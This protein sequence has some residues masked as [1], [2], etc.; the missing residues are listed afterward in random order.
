VIN[1][2]GLGDTKENFSN[3]GLHLVADTGNFIVVT[4]QALS[5]PNYNL[6]AWNSGA[7]YMGIV[8]NQNVN[9]VDFISTLIDSIS[10]Q[11]N[12]DSDRIYATGFSMGGF[13]SNRLACE[14][15]NRIA[16]IAPVAGTIG[17]SLTSCNPGRPVPVGHF[18]G[19]ADQTVG[20]YNN[21]YGI[22]VDSLIQFWI[23]NNGCQNI[24][25]QTQFLDIKNDGYTVDHFIYD[26]QCTNG[27]VVEL[28]RVNNAD[29]VWIYYP[30][31][32]IDYASEIWRFLSRFKK[33]T[34]TTYASNNELDKVNIYPNPSNGE[35]FITGISS[36]ATVECYDVSG[37]KIFSQNRN[38]SNITLKLNKGIYFV[39][40]TDDAGYSG[41]KK[42]II[43]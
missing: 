41:T 25:T 1:L 40:I 38:S 22:N 31:N 6:T 33:S 43:E 5:D 29:H 27:A 10:A 4:P 9:D 37:R 19:T 23:T 20:Y 2:H 14:L 35:L 26:N 13:M 11:Y 12:I 8:L 34:F 42:V 39:R 15:S 36:S 18:H 24:F 30:V 7:S 32:D 17:A 21:A 16:A 28:F 3:N